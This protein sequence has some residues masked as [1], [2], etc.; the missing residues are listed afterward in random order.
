MSNANDF[1][2]ENGVLTKYVGTEKEVVIPEGTLSIG[3]YAFCE[4]GK[5][6]KVWIP[7][8]VTV[9]GNNAFE[10][11]KKL[12]DIT[13][14]ARLTEIGD[15]AFRL[16]KK[17]KRVEI[18]GT[19]K[20]TGSMAF[21][22]CSGLESVVLNDGIKIIGYCSFADCTNLAQI[23]WPDSL[24]IISSESFSK[25][26]VLPEVNLH[27]GIHKVESGAFGGCVS[28]N[29]VALSKAVMDSVDAKWFR[30]RFSNVDL[31]LLWLSEKTNF[32]DRVGALCAKS[33]LRKKDEYSALI[34]KKNDGQAMSNFLKLVDKVSL[35]VL[36][37]YIADSGEI[38][39]ADI[40]AVLLNYKNKNY[41]TGEVDQI[42]EERTEKA[43]GFKEYTVADWKRIFKITNF[44]GD[45]IISGYKG[46]L[47]A[48]TIPAK[49]GK[50]RVLTFSLAYH[51]GNKVANADLCAKITEVTIETGILGVG[52]YAFLDCSALQTLTIPEG[53]ETIDYGAFWRCGSLMELRIPKSVA[54]ISPKAI[55]NCPKLTIYAPAGSYAETYAKEHNIPFVAE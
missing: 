26:K 51:K 7:D 31:N 32:D 6:T 11:C 14:P 47:Q 45:V 19:C 52:E 17:L 35:D 48:V 49:I 41:T 43:L 23:N 39:A 54:S 20:S 36:D 4:N 38:G 1:I 15:Q 24:E 5:L 10:K 12:E 34:I 37:R 13:L 22:G 55:W 53:V 18:P 3:A 2:F 8:S 40:S 28:V 9:I 33:I 44:Y 16:C 27:E 46:A 25:C 30:S 50:N 29:R 21:W 42:E